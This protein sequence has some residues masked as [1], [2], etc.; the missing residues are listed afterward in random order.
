MFAALVVCFYENWN[1]GAFAIAVAVVIWSMADL[2]QPFFQ[3][4]VG[5]CRKQS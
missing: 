3:G 4:L 1:R 5:G 2:L